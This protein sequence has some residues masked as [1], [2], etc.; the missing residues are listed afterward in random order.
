[1][2]ASG[3]TSDG[4]VSN[5]SSVYN[6][7]KNEP[8]GSFFCICLYRTFWG[9]IFVSDFYI[10]SGISIPSNAIALYNTFA[11]FFANNRRRAFFDA[12]GSFRIL[13]S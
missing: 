8:V 13:R 2:F 12:S 6:N 5:T 4:C 7:T 9:E 3:T 10:L 1:M 11:T